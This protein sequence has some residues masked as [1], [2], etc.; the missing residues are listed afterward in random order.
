MPIR[1][2]E[3]TKVSLAVENVWVAPEDY[4]RLLDTLV[5]KSIGRVFRSTDPI[6]GHTVSVDRGRVH[7]KLQANRAEVET[8]HPHS[9]DIERFAEIA[10]TV[11]AHASPIDPATAGQG[12]TYICNVEAACQQDSRESAAQYIAGRFFHFSN[13]MGQTFVPVEGA[14]KVGFR[15]PETNHVW[16]LIVEP[17]VASTDSVGVF[18]VLNVSFVNSPLPTDAT[19]VASIFQLV[20][21]SAEAFMDALEAPN[22]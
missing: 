18:I 2:E 10:A 11:F 1:I 13:R 17:L 7:T 14:L 12:Y 4:Q 16:R 9:Q 3:L 19:A 20:T 21:E 15:S 6:E 22:G 5:G 8:S